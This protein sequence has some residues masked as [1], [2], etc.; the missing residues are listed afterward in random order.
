MK[1]TLLTVVFAAI[2]LALVGAWQLLW[3]DKD[4]PIRVGVLHSL[5]GTMA[6]SEASLV[7]AIKMAIEELNAEGG[8]SGGRSKL[9]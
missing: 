2:L 9:L 5:S 1:K 8:S 6:I 3:R 4:R 7:D